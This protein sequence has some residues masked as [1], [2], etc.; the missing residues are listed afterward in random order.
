M[1]T[2]LGATYQSVF[3]MSVLCQ[4]NLKNQPTVAG[5]MVQQVKALATKVWQPELIPGKGGRRE[6][7]PK[8]SSDL[9]PHM[10]A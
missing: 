8:S 10:P 7:T 2:C 1:E 3:L 6:L 5:E 4:Q 9:H